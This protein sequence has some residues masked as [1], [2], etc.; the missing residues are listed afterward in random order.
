ML[1]VPVL[2]VV[3]PDQTQ[4][5]VS[6]LLFVTVPPFKV[7][8]LFKVLPL[9]S[10]V[11]PFA[12][13]FRL[14]LTLVPNEPFEND[15]TVVLLVDTDTVPFELDPNRNVPAAIAVPALYVLAPVSV[16]VPVLPVP[17]LMFNAKAPLMIPV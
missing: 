15:D 9:R 5:A 13:V 11:A 7:N 10:R 12:R 2:K 8:G 16:I 6:V 3:L 14:A 4:V 17:L 1:F